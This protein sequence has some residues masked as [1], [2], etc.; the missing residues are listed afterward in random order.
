MGLARYNNKP[1]VF[2]IDENSLRG[3]PLGL[4][5]P[6]TMTTTYT[7]PLLPHKHVWYLFPSSQYLQGTQKDQDM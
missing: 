4:I 6:S 1:T 5:L 7:M 3:A 2:T